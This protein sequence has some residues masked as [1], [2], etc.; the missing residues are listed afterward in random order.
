M[1]AR[2]NANE[3]APL[4]RWAGSK[5]KLLPTLLR[6]VPASFARYLEPFA[7]SACLFFAIKPIHAVLGDTNQE[8]IETYDT[9]RRHPTRIARALAKLPRNSATYYRIRSTTPA[10]LGVIARTTRFLYL[11]RLCFNG[12]YRT[13]RE[14]NFNVPMGTN[15]GDM[16]SERNFGDCAALLA[17]ADLRCRDF[18][19]TLSDVRSGDFIY[20]DPPYSSTVR[21]GYGEYG[22]GAFGNSDLP[23]LKSTLR[24]IHTAGATF[25]LSYNYTHSLAHDFRHWNVYRLQVQRHVAGFSH[26]RRRVSEMLVSNH[27]LNLTAK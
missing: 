21:P 13:N 25:L 15:T 5:R 9:I 23:R 16:P 14:G 12:V 2:S 18:E 8:L 7:G 24:A 1:S 19:E 22:Y 27:P 10:S 20:L 26:F 11:N 17:R 4:L 3:L 6:A